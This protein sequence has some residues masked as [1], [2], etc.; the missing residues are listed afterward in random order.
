VQQLDDVWRRRD[1]PVLVAAVSAVDK[2]ELATTRSLAVATGLEPQ[3]V[4]MAF[5][6][7]ERRG[8][9]KARYV[10]SGHGWISTLSDEAYRLTGQHSDC[11]EAAA[12]LL[13]ALEQVSERSTSPVDQSKLRRAADALGDLDAQ[14][15]GQVL[16]SF[17]TRMTGRV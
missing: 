12:G 17:L 13:H 3:H 1:L 15:L 10:L 5:Q 9:I 8:L 16:S 4:L 11:G 2:G 14:I 6:A 7:L